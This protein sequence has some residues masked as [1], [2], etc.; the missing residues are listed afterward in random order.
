MGASGRLGAAGEGVGLWLLVFA[1][2][3]E[4]R[5][6]V[7]G[8]GVVCEDELSGGEVERG[9]GGGV[10]GIRGGGV[11]REGVGRGW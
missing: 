9:A 1:I 7:F 5:V 2:A 6:E 8:D 4:H 10:G 11:G 3:A